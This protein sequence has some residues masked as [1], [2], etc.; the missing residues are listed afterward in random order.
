AARFITEFWRMTPKHHFG[1]LSDAQLISVLLV[2][3][4]LAA[5]AY[6]QRRKSSPASEV[7]PAMK[8]RKVAADK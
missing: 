6:L 2:L 1:G 7:T 8:T 3:G 5:L 4:G